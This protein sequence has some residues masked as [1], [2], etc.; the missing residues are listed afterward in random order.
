MFIVIVG[1]HSKWVHVRQMKNI[2]TE[3]I[4]KELQEY[5]SLWGIPAKLVTDNEP[6]LCSV[7]MEAILAKIGFFHNK[8]FPYSRAPNGAAKNIDETFKNFL[9]K[10]V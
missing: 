3:S 4:I 5:F 1:A 7:E 6:S 8:T 10:N 2:T 9:K